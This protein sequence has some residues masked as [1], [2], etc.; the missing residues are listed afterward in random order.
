MTIL[1]AFT[2]SPII[3]GEKG[4]NGLRSSGEIQGPLALES[5]GD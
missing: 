3:T 5:N 2:P 1:I 4:V